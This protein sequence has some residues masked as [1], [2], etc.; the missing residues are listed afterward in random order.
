MEQRGIRAVHPPA[1]DEIIDK[2]AWAID[3]VVRALVP[4]DPAE[5]KR[6]VS[7]LASRYLREN[8]S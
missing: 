8:G 6:V 1:T 2:E 7:Y 3:Q 5:R 4:L